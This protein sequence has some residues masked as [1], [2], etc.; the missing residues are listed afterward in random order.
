MRTLVLV[1]VSC[2]A[3]GLVPCPV[4]ADGKADPAAEMDAAAKAFLKAY[5]DKD[6]DAMMAAADAPF[7]V[8]TVRAPK[9]LKKGADLRGELRSR[10]DA[11][12]KLAGRV[13]KTL[14]RARAISPSAGAEREKRMRELMKP[15]IDVTGED[16]GYAALADAKGRSLAVSSTRLL[17][18]LRDGKAKVV[19]ILADPKGR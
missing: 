16:G 3:F 6:V 11:G 2:V 17:V 10:L 14:T 15:A 5:H 7:L 8:G 18:G 4:R 1:S 12:D 19:G 13:A 9:I